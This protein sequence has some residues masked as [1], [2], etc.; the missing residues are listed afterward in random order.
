M[1]KLLLL[2][3]ITLSAI[4]YSQEILDNQ[5]IIDLI[6]LDFEEGVIIAKIESSDTNNET[7]YTEVENE[8]ILRSETELLQQPT[9]ESL[10]VSAFKNGNAEKIALKFNDNVDL[11]IDGKEDL[12]S[13]SQS[14][15]ILKTFFL[16]HKPKDFKLIHKGKSG[17]N[18]Y[19][20]GELI[21]DLVYRVTINSKVIKGVNKIIS[22]TI[23]KD[24]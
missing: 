22:L 16:Q 2:V 17:Q 15:Q 14:E 18:E 3:A 19:I 7:E 12:Y 23:E 20:I 1:K 8:S 10:M 4:S 6:H 9:F 24:Y 11:S 21:S 13:N 5:S